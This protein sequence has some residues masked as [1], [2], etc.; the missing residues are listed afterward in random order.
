MCHVVLYVCMRCGCGFVLWI[1]CTSGRCAVLRP[2]PN[3]PTPLHHCLW[4]RPERAGHCQATPGR[5]PLWPPGI[6]GG[7]VVPGRWWP[8]PSAHPHPHW[9]GWE[10]VPH[11]VPCTLRM[12]VWIPPLCG[13]WSRRF[14]CCVKFRMYFWQFAKYALKN[15]FLLKPKYF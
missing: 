1:E 3:P 9:V 5:P 11:R 15:N 6:G 7:R 13:Q 4:P 14:C 8:R 2:L 12:G 10:G